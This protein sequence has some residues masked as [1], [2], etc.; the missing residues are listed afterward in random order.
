MSPRGGTDRARR[1]PG[2]DNRP[3]PR[4]NAATV[5]EHR[6][7]VQSALVDA[8]ERILREQGPEALTASAVTVSAG[9]ARNSIYRYVESVDDLRGLVLARHLPQWMTAVGS[10]VEGIDDPLERICTWSRANL[11]Q[12][13]HTGHG[14]LMAVARGIRLPAAENE[15][16]DRA[17]GRTADVLRASMDELLA[18]P[19]VALGVEL[20]RSLV[21]AG[22]RRLDAG[23]SPT[24]VVPHV[25]DAVR[26]T[27]LSLRD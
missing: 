19:L 11:E 24:V 3:V 2:R 23:E 12:A 18:G 10:A 22:F 21:D 6:A 15:A 9:I 5:K 26:A 13:A 14:W 1:G 25:V 4:I 27:L 16:L 7:N 8:A 17:H 20:V